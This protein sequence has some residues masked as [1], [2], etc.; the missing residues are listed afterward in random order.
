MPMSPHPRLSATV[1]ELCDL[2]ED[3]LRAG[4][5]TTLNDWLTVAGPEADV[6]LPELVAIELDHRIRAGEEVAAADYFILFPQLRSDPPV[7]IWLVRIEFLAVRAT[8]TEK[9]AHDRLAR[10][11]SLSDHPAWRGGPWAAPNSADSTFTAGGPRAE[12]MDTSVE[13]IPLLAPA[14]EPDE[15]GRLGQYRV[16][17]T[18]GQGGMGVVFYA[19]DAHLQRPVAIKVMRPQI[20]QNPASRQRFLAEARAAAKVTSDHVVT[21]YQIAEAGGSAF[22]AME[23]LRGESLD[24]FLKRTPVAPVRQLIRVAREIAT[25]LTAAHA[26]GVVHRD[27]KPGNIWLEAPNGRVKILDFGLA[28]ATDSGVQLTHSGE[29]VGTPAYM[30]PEQANGANVDPRT[31]LFSLGAVMYRMATGEMPFPGSSPMAVL[32]SLANTTPLPPHAVNP[33]VPTALSDLIMRLLAKD[34]EQRPASASEI[35]SALAAIESQPETPHA[36]L[37]TSV[38]ATSPKQ[39]KRRSVGVW[40]A[41]GLLPLVLATVAAG[42]I[43][44]I[45]RPDGKETTFEAPDGSTVK[46]DPKGEVEITLPKE[47]DQQAAVSPKPVNPP[48]TE[49]SPFDQLNAAQIPVAERFDWQPKELVAVLGSHRQ[50]H[51]M[52][53]T[54][55]RTGLAVQD[56]G[57][58]IASS[59]TDGL[60]IWDAST[61]DLI[62]HVSTDANPLGRL[63][64][65]TDGN[66]LMWLVPREKAKCDL[67]VY[68]IAKKSVTWQAMDTGKFTYYGYHT[69]SK[70]RKTLVMYAVDAD[71]RHML[72][73]WDMTGDKPKFLYSHPGV[74]GTLSQDGTLLA[75][76]ESDEKK[77]PQGVQLHDV[78]SG[79]L[80]PRV[81]LPGDLLHPAF[82]PDGR[83]VT[84][85]DD[86]SLVGVGKDQKTM[87][88]WNVEKEKP[89]Q[90][91]EVPRAGWDTCASSPD[92]KLIATVYDS[93]NHFG[94]VRADTLQF[95][96]V[97]DW[98]YGTT[99]T[100]SRLCFHPDGST[101]Y[102]TTLGGRILSC[103]IEGEKYSVAK[104]VVNSLSADRNMSC[105][106]DGKLVL[107]GS[108]PALWRLN[109]VAPT[110]WKQLPA[111]YGQPISVSPSGNTFA[112]SRESDIQI[113]QEKGFS[114]ARTLKV[115]LRNGFR[116][117][118]VNDST[119][120]LFRGEGSATKLEI[121][122][123]EANPP[124]L[125]KEYPNFYPNA[126][127]YW[128]LC[129]S[130]NGKAVAL[131]E[132]PWGPGE[133]RL[134]AVDVSKAKPELWADIPIQGARHLGVSADGQTLAV[135]RADGWVEVW[136]NKE[137]KA[138]R[139]ELFNLGD[140]TNGE[141]FG[142]G[143]ALNPDGKRLAVCERVGRITLW[144][145]GAGKSVWETTLPGPA[146]RMMFAGDG[147]H[148][149]TMNSN[150]TIYVLRLAPAK[151]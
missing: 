59:A 129:C 10:Y 35:V 49:R 18:L 7:A 56:Q 16:L 89:Q 3:R 70:D 61:L 98:K 123:V 114:I 39:P 15:I 78:S 112:L 111:E 64:F 77:Q 149:I 131:I 110:A 75:I 24:D 28:R 144:D 108:T 44:K 30:S 46:V 146:Y 45:N 63:D 22:V 84:F 38:P 99:D 101:F 25:G 116:V 127:G 117:Q 42:V 13:L 48:P 40:V 83:L 145:I 119:L 136:K 14:L 102:L 140:K 29:I 33:D 82:L 54:F 126:V 12:D 106:L 47:K 125:L 71:N 150:Q 74:A 109:A 19:E 128:E 113:L 107:P 58:L 73:F 79:G 135:G 53:A 41:L 143:F 137:G 52:G 88:I 9:A 90:I 105:S 60:R 104:W 86:P 72:L 8:R 2:F 97:G 21:I 141:N 133:R 132:G 66:R 121:W 65:S 91:V 151:Y 4:E 85:N 51:W 55:F 139:E 80:K 103:R 37:L 68:D 95:L 76:E 134:R 20:A 17:T 5:R 27:I 87:R 34:P 96:K 148:L 31:D 23:L 69:Y 138:V 120:A 122:D 115:D 130:S 81:K 32:S 1:D 50:R 43:I 142:S 67:G 6:A 118:L 36:A 92:G 26:Q 11:E 93:F 62:T 124:K 94:I 147:R 100:W 57:Q